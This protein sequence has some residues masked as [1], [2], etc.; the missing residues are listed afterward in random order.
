MDYAVE[1]PCR[2]FDAHGRAAGSKR[3]GLATTLTTGWWI[4]AATC[5]A[6]ALLAILSPTGASADQ[7]SPAPASPF[8]AGSQPVALATGDA[9]GDGQIDMVA[10]NQDTGTLTELVA[11]R[12]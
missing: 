3:S 12:P 6:L 11:R 8:A 4:V 10:A 1:E 2:A 7:F 9:N 5:M